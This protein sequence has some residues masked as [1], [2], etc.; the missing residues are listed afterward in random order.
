MTRGPHRW[1]RRDPLSDAEALLPRVLAYV[2][3]RIGDGPDAEDVTADV[4]ARAAR[5]RESY[6]ASKGPPITWL[7]GIA[8]RCIDD[9]LARPRAE[10]DPP[11]VASPEDVEEKIGTRLTLA[12][13]LSDLSDK[14]QE[15]IA[16]RYGAD[17]SA[18]QIGRELGMTPGAVDV[19]IH[20]A[21]ER[22]RKAL[23]DL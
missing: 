20:R 4:F 17:M 8:R 21:L 14:D 7:L 16:L 22:L 5:Y 13:G 19:A 18:R 2:A 6:D 3:Y 15:L 23:E 1:L 12:A 9:E 10:P 11:D